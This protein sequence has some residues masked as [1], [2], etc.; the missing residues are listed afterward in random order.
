MLVAGVGASYW[1]AH[2]E[3][4]DATQFVPSFQIQ[5]QSKAQR[6]LLQAA[7]DR[8]VTA[9][10]LAQIAQT[11]DQWSQVVEHW[12]TALSALADVPEGHPQYALAQD[13]QVEYQRNLTYSK[14]RQTAVQDSFRLAV[15]AAT[16]AANQ[17][18]SATTEQDWL[19]IAALWQTAVEQ[20]QAV[21]SNHPRYGIAQQRIPIYQ[22]NLEYAQYRSQRLGG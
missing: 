21:S 4:V 19:T 3:A 22:S 8:A 12:Q 17:G 18:Q 5:A 9:A 11:P 7:Y 16:A 14:Q 15:Q 10:T 20:M 2:E 1:L 13:K 6:N